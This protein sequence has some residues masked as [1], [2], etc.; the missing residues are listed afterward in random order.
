MEIPPISCF[1]VPYKENSKKKTPEISFRGS[2][3][4]QWTAA[5]YSHHI[6]AAINLF[7][8]P[9]YTVGT[10]IL[11]K[12]SHRFGCCKA[13]RGLYRRLGLT[14]DPED[15]IP[16]TCINITLY[17]QDC[18]SFLRF[19]HNPLNEKLNST[20]MLNLVLLSSSISFIILNAFYPQ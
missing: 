13:V 9:D 16:F 7:S 10:G 12:E 11:S 8:H 6:Q 4:I 17:I 1:R 20:F 15:F 14:P 19:V 5:R 3:L 2:F 18:N